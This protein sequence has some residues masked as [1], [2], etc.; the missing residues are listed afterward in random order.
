MELMSTHRLWLCYQY[1]CSTFR[2]GTQ[3]FDFMKRNIIR[4]LA[5]KVKYVSQINRGLIMFFRNSRISFFKLAG[6]IGTN[7]ER[8]TT[9]KRNT[10]NTVQCSKC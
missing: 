7:M 10:I 9:G 3:P 1:L 5:T 4:K 2:K 6:S 8:L